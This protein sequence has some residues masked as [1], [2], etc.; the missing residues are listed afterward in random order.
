MRCAVAAHLLAACVVR[1][2]ASALAVLCFQPHQSRKRAAC[3]TRQRSTRR[4]QIFEKKPTRTKNF[5][6]WLRHQSRTGY[7]NM[8]KEYRDLTLNGAVDQ[9]YTEMA[10]RHRVR[11]HQLHIIK[12]TVVRDADCK[13][14]NIMQFLDP[15]LKFP[16][17]RKCDTPQR[18]RKVPVG[19]PARCPLRLFRLGVVGRSRC[20]LLGSGGVTDLIGAGAV[21]DCAP[22]EPQVPEPLQR[23]PTN[24]GRVLSACAQCIEPR[25][26]DFCSPGH[27]LQ[28]VIGVAAAC[29]LQM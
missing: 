28:Y 17:T 1:V 26:R 11:S 8:Y 21:Q 29:I 3:S 19:I 24:A 4:A 14:E 10:S 13:R 18:G 16:V 22:G 6:I 20:A 25:G 2:S 27:V 15:K 5:G 12:T 23:E 9:M 7:H